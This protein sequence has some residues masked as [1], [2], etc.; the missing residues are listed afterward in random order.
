MCSP[1]V[2][3]RGG[4]FRCNKCGVFLEAVEDHNYSD[5]LHT[6]VVADY[7]EDPDAIRHEDTGLMGSKQQPYVPAAARSEGAT[8]IKRQKEVDREIRELCAQLDAPDARTGRGGISGGTLKKAIR[9][10]LPGRGGLETD[11]CETK[12]T[13]EEVAAAAVC[14]AVQHDRFAMSA[15]SVNRTV[16]HSKVVYVLVCVLVCSVLVC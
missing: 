16:S 4:I 8:H 10:S 2:C 13:A 14:V 15:T 3:V 9:L 5:M 1:V 11:G 7:G 6:N 12:P